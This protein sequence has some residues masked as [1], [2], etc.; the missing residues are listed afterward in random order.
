MATFLRA[1]AWRRFD[2]QVAAAQWVA[3]M[4]RE[5]DMLQP[6]TGSR[7][8]LTRDETPGR[9]VVAYAFG[10]PRE[11]RAGGRLESLVA[12]ESLLAADPL[13]AGEALLMFA[14]ECLVPGLSPASGRDTP[15]LFPAE[16]GREALA[17][18]EAATA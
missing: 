3:R 14:S 15:W 11:F 1:Y 2:T 4:F 9:F 18:A 16:C 17:T 7:C 6:S 10:F 12:L 5:A 8:A 13:V